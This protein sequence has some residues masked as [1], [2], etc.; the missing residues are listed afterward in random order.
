MAEKSML[1]KNFCRDESGQDLVEY[2]LIAAVI[3]LGTISVLQG[4]ANSI[5]TLFAAVG[6]TLTTAL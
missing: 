5:A 4:V 1:L 6:T 2:G 3:A